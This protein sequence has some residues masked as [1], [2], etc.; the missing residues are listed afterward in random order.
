MYE[1]SFDWRKCNVTCC[2]WYFLNKAWRIICQRS[3]ENYTCSL[4]TWEEEYGIFPMFVLNWTIDLNS[5]FALQGD[6]ATDVVLR[7]TF[8]YLCSVCVGKWHKECSI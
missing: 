3:L 7:C 1:T 2:Y 5:R 8:N 6:E 4:T